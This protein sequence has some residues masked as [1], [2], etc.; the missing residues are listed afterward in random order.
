MQLKPTSGGKDPAPP[1]PGQEHLDNRRQLDGHVRG[2]TSPQPP[3]LV[4]TPGRGGPQPSQQSL[5]RLVRQKRPQ[6]SHL[7]PP[8]ED[9]EHDG[10]QPP[11]RLRRH[12]RIRRRHELEL[13]PDGGLQAGPTQQPTVG[14]VVRLVVGQPAQNGHIMRKWS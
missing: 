10:D 4:T 13:R 2:I 1:L 11:Q 3:Q 7:P 8:V 14:F 6:L 5:V 9:L 12:R